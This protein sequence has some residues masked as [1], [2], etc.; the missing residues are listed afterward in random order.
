MIAIKAFVRGIVY[1][2]VCIYMVVYEVHE[3]VIVYERRAY[4]IGFEAFVV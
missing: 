3:Y 4:V 2:G 1:E